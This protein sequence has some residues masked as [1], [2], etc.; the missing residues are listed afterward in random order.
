MEINVWAVLAAA[1]SA[2]VL[3]G[4]WYGALFAKVWQTQS[5]VTDEQLANQNALKIFGLAFVLSLLSAL[6]FHLFLG[7]DPGL[8][9]ALFAGVSAGLGWVAAALGVIY[10]FEHR[11]L[12]H[13][14]VNGAYV[15]LMFTLFGLVFGLMG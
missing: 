10:L 8:E 4:I 15:T 2:F 11:P 12:G 7:R 14:L 6:V 1:V 3:G 13:F 9:F 5:G